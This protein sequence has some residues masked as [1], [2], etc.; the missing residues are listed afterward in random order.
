MGIDDDENHSIRIKIHAARCRRTDTGMNAFSLHADN[1][2]T[3]SDGR[4]S[5]SKPVMVTWTCGAGIL[6][7]MRRRHTQIH[8]YHSTCVPTYIHIYT[9]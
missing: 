6:K 2:V 5:E 9:L 1:R 7:P 4:K 8:A 3:A